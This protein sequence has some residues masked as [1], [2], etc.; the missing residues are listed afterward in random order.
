MIY[1]A[2]ETCASVAGANFETDLTAA[3]TAKSVTAPT[4][5][6]VIAWQ[7]AETAVRLG[8]AKPLLGV[9]VA[10]QSATQAKSQGKRDSLSSV[11]F[12]AYLENADPTLVVKQIALV[13]EAVML[14]VDRLVAGVGGGVYGGAVTPLSVSIDL[15]DG[16]EERGD[17]PLYWQR[18]QIVVPVWDQDTGL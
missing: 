5:W 12:D 3:C 17:Q 13:P 9:T 2:V 18:A 1:D 6:K 14:T 15:T 7:N 4:G 8:A 16:Y 10:P 11:L